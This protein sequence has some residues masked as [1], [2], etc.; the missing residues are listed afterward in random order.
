MLEKVGI[1]ATH[2]G[3]GGLVTPAWAAGAAIVDIGVGGW[4][5]VTTIHVFIPTL[6]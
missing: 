2:V 1:K 5:L 4:Y 6:P 3:F